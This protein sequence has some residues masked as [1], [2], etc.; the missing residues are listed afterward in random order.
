MYYFFFFFP[1][2]S[3]A[4]LLSLL[5]L[6]Q[7]NSMSFLIFV[8]PWVGLMVLLIYLVCFV[9]FPLGPSSLGCLARPSA[10]M[11]GRRSLPLSALFVGAPSTPHKSI[12]LHGP[13]EVLDCLGSAWPLKLVMKGARGPNLLWEA[14]LDFDLVEA[15]DG[16]VEEPL[17]MEAWMY[18]LQG[19]FHALVACDWRGHLVEW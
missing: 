13:I 10:W 14:F 17:A 8:L 19:W 11:E 16:T 3:S 1:P 6:A 12:S 15:Q 4:S 7:P 2:N 18:S 9:T 5:H